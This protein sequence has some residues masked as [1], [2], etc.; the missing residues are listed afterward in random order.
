VLPLGFNVL[1]VTL[2]LTASGPPARRASF[3]SI[4]IAIALQIVAMV[5][6]QVRIG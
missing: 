3:A 5:C 6:T 1:Q 2:A 4:P